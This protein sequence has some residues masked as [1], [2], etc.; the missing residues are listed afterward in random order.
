MFGDDDGS[1]KLKKGGALC[2]AVVKRALTFLIAS[3]KISV[4]NREAKVTKKQN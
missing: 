1:Y 2:K 3:I 4:K